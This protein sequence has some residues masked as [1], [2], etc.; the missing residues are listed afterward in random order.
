MSFW[1]DTEMRESANSWFQLILVSKY[2]LY[3][4]NS[5]HFDFT[6]RRWMTQNTAMVEQKIE[7]AYPKM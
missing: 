2:T 3:N 5:G 6:F 7:S 4:I 1:Y